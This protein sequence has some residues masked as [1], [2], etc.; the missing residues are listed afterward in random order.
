[1]NELELLRQPR[2]VTRRVVIA[3][4]IP[5]ATGILEAH[6]CKVMGTKERPELILPVG[7]LQT[8]V[9]PRIW[10][11]RYTILLPDG[12]SFLEMLGRDGISLLYLPASD[13]TSIP[14]TEI[15]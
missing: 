1:M 4:L 13:V 14:G 6:G 11:A 15:L 2:E 8:E 3:P 10:H 7:T 12:Y 9:L 5:G